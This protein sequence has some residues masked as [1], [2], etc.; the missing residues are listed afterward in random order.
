LS[1]ATIELVTLPAFGDATVVN[2]QTILYTPDSDYVGMDY[3]RY[4]LED[5][6]GL[7][8][9]EAEVD[10]KVNAVAGE[11]SLED[12]FGVWTGVFTDLSGWDVTGFARFRVDGSA[13]ELLVHEDY[14]KSNNNAI[15]SAVMDSAFEFTITWEMPTL[16]FRYELVGTLGTAFSTFS[17][18]WKFW[19][20]H[21]DAV[22][23]TTTGTFA[24]TK[25][26]IIATRELADLAG[27]WSGT[28]SFPDHGSANFNVQFEADGG[29][30]PGGGAFDGLKGSGAM[31]FVGGQ[32]LVVEDNRGLYAFEFQDEAQEYGGDDVVQI[33]GVLPE[34]T[35]VWSGIV[36]HYFWGTGTF[37]LERP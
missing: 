35:N 11:P 28:M 4:R 3:F 1:G 6:D 19:D 18:T 12:L 37:Q 13:D 9:N 32:G 10:V 31:V 20:T 33:Q 29:F 34:S 36:E 30:N 16:F 26:P 7:I 2:N 23:P 8:S 15:G 24:I 25:S 17:G 14:Y 5:E 21:E 27:S 22:N